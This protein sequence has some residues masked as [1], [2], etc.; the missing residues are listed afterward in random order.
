MLKKLTFLTLA[1]CLHGEKVANAD[2]LVSLGSQDG[3]GSNQ[4]F[5]AGSRATLWAHASD[6]TVGSPTRIE[7]YSLAFQIGNTTTIPS[8]FSNFSVDFTGGMISNPPPANFGLFVDPSLI[9]AD[10]VPGHNIIISNA[11]D[12][13]STLV[14]GTLTRMFSIS[15][16]IN[17][18]ASGDFQFRF[19]PDA[20]QFGGPVNSVIGD[21]FPEDLGTH[22]NSAGTFYNQFSVTAVPEPGSLILIG[23]AFILIGY[24]RTRKG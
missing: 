7:A 16:D 11:I 20:M 3:S 23:S 21:G 8:I 18:G 15:F 14:P 13:G 19:V 9:Q 2:F 6:T 5:L 22:G 12:S 4:S 24:R 1:L 10:P 17:A